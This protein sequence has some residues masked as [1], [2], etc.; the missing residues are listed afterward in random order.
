MSEL[1]MKDLVSLCK[2][3]GFI[4]QS[5]EIYGGINGFWDYGPYGVELKNA[6]KKFW[7]DEMVRLR[8]DVVGQDAS[9]IMHPKVWEASG[10]VEGFND[11]M[12]DCKECKS[13]FRED[14][15]KN[16]EKCDKCGGELTEPKMF[17]LMLSTQI[18]ASE[19]SS[20]TAYLRPETAQSIFTNFKTIQKTSRKKIPFGIAQIGKAFRNE[21]TPRN[22]TFRSRE[23]EQM[24]MQYFVDP[25]S[26]TDHYEYWSE[27]R[28]NFFEKVGIPKEKIRFHEHGDELAHYASKA[29]D[30]EVEFPFGWQEV[31]GIHDRGSFDLTQHETFS[32]EDMKYFDEATKRKFIPHV[33]ETSIG[34]DR[35]ALAILCCAYH[36]E[37]LTKEG[38]KQDLRTVMRFKAHIAPVQ[39]AVLPLIKKLS[40]EAK[41]VE[42]LL[43][44]Y[45]FRTEFDT[46]GQIG[47]RYRRQDEIGTPFCVTYD[48]DTRDDH[49]V[50][51]RFRD[52]MEQK[53]VAISDLA[54]YIQ[55]LI[56]E[57]M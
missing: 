55:G 57:E 5:S 14:Q 43:K 21:I 11:P 48:F 50:T 18:G 32:K 31:E 26:E 53:R 3:K 29:R 42:I 12:V 49:Q 56:V 15:L 54:S 9:I 19:D 4:F 33:V 30:I 35:L 16:K 39:V 47:R 6:I 13:R 40:D 27:T 7:W 37:D 24:E 8:D 20:S 28:R 38:G 41:E 34:A 2:R 10:H 44:K 25:E 23:F 46:A 22:F 36:V 45:G 17:N 1:N 52:S 51:I